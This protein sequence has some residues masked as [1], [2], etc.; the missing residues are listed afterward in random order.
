MELRLLRYFVAIADER[1]FGRAAERLRIAQPSLSRAVQRLERELGAT[2]LLRSA[3]GVSMTPAG[4]AL[5]DEARTVLDQVEHATERVAAAASGPSTLTVGSL[6]GVLGDA[7]SL[8]MEAFR[9]SHPDVEVRVRESDFTDPS[10][11]LRAGLVDVSITMAPFDASGLRVHELRSDAVAVVMRA[12]DPLAT[13]AEL[14]GAEL[15]DRQWFRF[16]PATDPVWSAFWTGQRT[17]P[18]VRTAHE[19]LQAVLWNRS[20]GLIP[21]THQVPNGLTTVP[22]I[23]HPPCRLVVAWKDVDADPLIRSFVT[24]AA[25]LRW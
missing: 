6:A 19:C 2:L 7:G 14:T 12:D 22:L 8:L 18:T 3:A 9:E 20:V 17:G 21:G 4:A 15:A 13:R 11:G 1:H 10:C 25:Q 16:P 24:A 5:Y 23:D